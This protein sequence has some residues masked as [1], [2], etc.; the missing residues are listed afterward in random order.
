MVKKIAITL[1]LTAMLISIGFTLGLWD[2][3][4]QI[5]EPVEPHPLETIRSE[6][7]VAVVRQVF[8]V[9]YVA[10]IAVLGIV[11]ALVCSVDRLIIHRQ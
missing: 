10:L 8:N 7:G 5:I 1:I 6:V 4:A 11:A 9:I 3:V 2:D